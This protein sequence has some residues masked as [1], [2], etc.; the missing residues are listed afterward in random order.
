M[1]VFLK[2]LMPGATPLRPGFAKPIIAPD[3]SRARETLIG[4]RNFEAGVTPSDLAARLRTARLDTC[5]EDQ[6]DEA[7]RKREARI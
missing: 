4:S 1:L 7:Q 5:D 6:A 3:R 2:P